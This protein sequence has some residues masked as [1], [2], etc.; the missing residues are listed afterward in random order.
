MP[1]H[2]VGFEITETAAIANL[3]VAREFMDAMRELGCS[4]LLDDFG[5]G[6][7]S[8]A[9][10]KELP[11]DIIKIDG[12]FVRDMCEE[13]VD[14]AMVRSIHEIA[15]LTQKRTVAEHAEDEATI[16][17]LRALGVQYAQGFELGRPEPLAL[18][19]SHWPAD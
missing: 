4:F 19:L 14:F 1:T 17:L 6:L 2:Q 3:A 12:R 8:F 10:L 9:Y 7:S 15:A 11:V 18:L 5:A 16:D 13:P